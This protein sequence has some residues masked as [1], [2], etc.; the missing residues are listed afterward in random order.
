MECSSSQ[1]QKMATIEIGL[2]GINLAGLVKGESALNFRFELAEQSP[3]GYCWYNLFVDSSDGERR[4]A[5]TAWAILRALKKSA[6]PT[7][8]NGFRIIDGSQWLTMG[9]NNADMGV[10]G[11]TFGN[12]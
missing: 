8:L 2:P 1:W 12:T 10:D 5:R 4:S 6:D 7:H 11:M 3:P 9:D